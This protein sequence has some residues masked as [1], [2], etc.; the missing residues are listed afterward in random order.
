MGA[1]TSIDTIPLRHIHICAPNNPKYQEIQEL[2]RD[3][4]KSYQFLVSETDASQKDYTVQN[5]LN[6]AEIILVFLNEQ[7]TSDFAYLRELDYARKNQK[8][9]LFLVNNP[10]F[11]PL[12]NGGIKKTVEDSD[13][14]FY[15]SPQDRS[16]VETYLME[17]F[18]S[19]I[20]EVL[21]ANRI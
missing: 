18:A 1:S 15:T 6:R 9:I 17:N 14:E 21:S 7:S 5:T 19:N 16:R 13:W 3:S 20:T 12:Q 4:L 8:R 10:E 2:L 11:G